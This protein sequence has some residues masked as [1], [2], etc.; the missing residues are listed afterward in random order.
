MDKLK[1]YSVERLKKISELK[2][3]REIVVNIIEFRKV[4]H[5][6]LKIKPSKYQSTGKLGDPN[7]SGAKSY[8]VQNI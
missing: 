7:A 8:Q 6:F 2:N 3:D 4:L 1:S 5:Q